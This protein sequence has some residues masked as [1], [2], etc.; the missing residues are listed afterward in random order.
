MTALRRAPP[1]PVGRSANGGGGQDQHADTQHDAVDHERQHPDPF[2]QA[3][4][5]V[6]AKIS[7]FIEEFKERTEGED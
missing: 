4:E 6:D 1:R 7:E 5:K 3:H 2:Y